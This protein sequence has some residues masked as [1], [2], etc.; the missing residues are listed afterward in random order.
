[1]FRRVYLDLPEAEGKSLIFTFKPSISA[2]ILPVIPKKII[3][4]F[5]TLTNVG[6]EIFTKSPLPSCVSEFAKIRFFSALVLSTLAMKSS[7]SLLLIPA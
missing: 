1:M 2:V 6:V 3:S 7:C 4:L 5:R